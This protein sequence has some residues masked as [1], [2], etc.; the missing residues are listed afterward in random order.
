MIARQRT[1]PHVG[2]HFEAFLA[3]DGTL[4]SSTAVAL[5]RALIREI[6]RAM[7]AGR[8]STAE[9]ARRMKTRPAVVHGLLDRA[10]AR[11]TLATIN[12]AAMAL[13]RTLRLQL[14]E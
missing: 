5:K 10:D 9:L 1:N 8:V 12:K 14:G 6:T 11:V 3:D 13:G 2:S 7:K 4:V